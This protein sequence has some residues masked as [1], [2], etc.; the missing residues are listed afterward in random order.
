MGEVGPVPLPRAHTA[1]S[2]AVVTVPPSLDRPGLSE[3]P[4]LR[5]LLE[6]LDPHAR[7]TLRRV[8]IRD[9]ADRDAISSRLMRYRD[10]PGGDW[11]DIIDM[12]TLHPEARRQVARLLG[13]IDARK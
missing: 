2:I 9:Q 10:E 11:A 1:T 13:E 6:A 12:L 5:E 3:D 7:D 8:L 4:Y